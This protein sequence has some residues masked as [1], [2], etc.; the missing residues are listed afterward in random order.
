MVV[1][2]KVRS[3]IVLL[4]AVGTAFFIVHGATR[5]VEILVAARDLP[6]NTV[7]TED[8][9]K[10]VSIPAGG[11]FPG[12]VRADDAKAVI[13]SITKGFIPA[14]YPVS[15]PYLQEP[16]GKEGFGVTSRIRDPRN[17]LFPV[18]ASK[19]KMAA[20]GRLLAGEYADI[21]LSWSD[22]EGK[23][24]ISAGK[25]AA[26]KVTLYLQHQ[27]VFDYDGKQLTIEIPKATAAVLAFAARVG[28]I[29][30]TPSRVD[31]VI[32]AD[33]AASADVATLRAL[34]SKAVTDTVQ[35]KEGDER[36]RNTGGGRQ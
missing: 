2:K 3:Y 11:L 14:G 17:V 8:A 25:G 33:G 26:D 16:T 27:R 20:G 12:T 30:V 32:L 6:E 29:I 13:G 4:A 28:D 5:S 18:A 9:T 1:F 22:P 7:I 31:E 19:E 35:V 23:S 24:A 15:K 36:S 21:Y 34:F 10:P